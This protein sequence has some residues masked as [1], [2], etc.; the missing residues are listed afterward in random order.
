MLKKAT[1]PTVFFEKTFLS[2]QGKSILPRLLKPFAEHQVLLGITEP[3]RPEE[4]IDFH[5]NTLGKAQLSSDEGITVE[6]VSYPQQS[7]YRTGSTWLDLYDFND[8]ANF[9]I[10]ALAVDI[11]AQPGDFE[12]DGDVD[13]DDLARLCASWLKSID[14]VGYDHICDISNSKDNFINFK[15]FAELANNWLIGV[16]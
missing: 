10:K 2:L 11:V 13:I 1:L 14:D 9:C 5:F 16:E 15:D 4:F 3:P 12:P 7:F 6:S 8:T